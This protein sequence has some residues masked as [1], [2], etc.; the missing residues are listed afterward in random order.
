M[1]RVSQLDMVTIGYDSH[2]TQQRSFKNI[3]YHVELDS[4]TYLIA[5][6]VM[7]DIVNGIHS[8]INDEGEGENGIG[9][10]ERLKSRFIIM[11]YLIARFKREIVA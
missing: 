10:L 5:V 9:L 7:K 11:L 3:L 1:H 4:S 8:K 6:G 2:A